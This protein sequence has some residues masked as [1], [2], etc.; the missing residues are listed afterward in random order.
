MENVLTPTNIQAAS[1]SHSVDL[2]SASWMLL[3][4]NNK[5]FSFFF[6]SN[7]DCR[8]IDL[9]EWASLQLEDYFLFFSELKMEEYFNASRKARVRSRDDPRAFP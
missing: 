8:T 9:M 3:N 5:T 1:L 4:N 2:F 7:D 6:T